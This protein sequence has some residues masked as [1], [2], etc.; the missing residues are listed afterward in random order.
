MTGQPKSEIVSIDPALPDVDRFISA[1]VDLWNNA[2][3]EEMAISQAF[4]RYNLKPSV[5]VMRNLFVATVNERMV[6]VALATA[7]HGEPLVNADSEG[8]LDA[9][10]VEPGM[11]RRGVGRL[12]LGAAERWLVEQGCQAVQVGGGLRPFTP[13]APET[14][15][16]TAFFT[17]HGY[18]HLGVSWD[19]AANLA[20][21]APPAGMREAP[22]A[23]R[24]ATPSHAGELLNFLRREFPGRWRYEAE[25][26]LADGGRISDFM[27]LWSERGVDGCCLLT[28]PDSVRPLERFYP[29]QL[30][31][32]WGQLGSIGVSADRRGQ[33]FGAALLDAGLRR[34]HNNG[35]NGCVIDWTTL[36][37]FYGK[38]GFERYRA[39]AMLGRRL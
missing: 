37:D 32:P 13:G 25:M 29:Y 16:A 27:L 33:G 7:L 39:Y 19:M 23:V 2:L 35:V 21:Y 30:P 9:L 38:F 3:G 22:C 34:L 17:R 14:S 36:L 24:P 12:L 11:Q 28:F 8:W 26:F 6:G 31:K 1:F 20:T 10:V 18:Q 5:G 15:G 4:V